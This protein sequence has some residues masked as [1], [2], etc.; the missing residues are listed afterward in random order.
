MN[1]SFVPQ[2]LG[3]SVRGVDDW[4]AQGGGLQWEAQTEVGETLVLTEPT[5]SCVIAYHIVSLLLSGLN[6]L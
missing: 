6:N 4:M 2:L 3:S 5:L 1:K